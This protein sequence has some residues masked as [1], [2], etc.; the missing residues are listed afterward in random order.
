VF[1]FLSEKI[2]ANGVGR[3]L[4]EASVASGS[5][6][7]NALCLYVVAVVEEAVDVLCFPQH[8]D[9]TTRENKD[10]RTLGR[11]GYSR[12]LHQGSVFLDE[13]CARF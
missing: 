10:H 7:G 4:K 5:V 11:D 3:I 1:D 2:P 9:G 8:I 6:M 12:L 13:A